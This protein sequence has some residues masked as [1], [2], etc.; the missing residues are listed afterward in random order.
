MLTYAEQCEF[1]E[2][3]E[4]AVRRNGLTRCSWRV[5]ANAAADWA[6]GTISFTQ[7]IRRC[8]RSHRCRSGK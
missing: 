5:L 3:L 1:T 4:L 6:D 7:A 8:E 2:A